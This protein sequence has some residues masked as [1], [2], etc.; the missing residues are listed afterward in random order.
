MRVVIVSG[1]FD[2]IHSGHI[3]HFKAAK[4]LGDV[5]IVG[6]NS[7]DWLTRKKGKPFLPIDERLAVVASMRMVDSAVPFNDDDNSSISLI[8]SALVLFDDVVFANGGDRTQDNIPEIDAFDK[9][10]RVQFAFGVGGTHKQNSSSWILKE[11]NSTTK[12]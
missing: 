8:K 2:P 12:T 4:K 9:D 6:C 3:D 11:W 1:G 10:P 5:L 7:D